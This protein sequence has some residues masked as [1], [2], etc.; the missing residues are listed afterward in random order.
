MRE[1]QKKITKMNVKVKNEDER[2][3]ENKAMQK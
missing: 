3:K 1:E 2:Q